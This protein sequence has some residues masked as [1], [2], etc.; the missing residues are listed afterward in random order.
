MKRIK[1]SNGGGPVAQSKFLNVSQ[2]NQ[3]QTAFKLKVPITKNIS[4]SKEIF[5]NKNQPSFNRTSVK[6]QKNWN[7]VNNIE[8]TF[9]KDKFGKTSGNITYTRT[10]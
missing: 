7:N 3:K 6:F 10:I 2:L 5:K 4:V 9:S 1:Y 8:G